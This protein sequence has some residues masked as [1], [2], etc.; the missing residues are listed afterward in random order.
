VRY[1]LDTNALSGILGQRPIAQQLL[2]VRSRDIGISSIVAFEAYFGAFNGGR[3]RE[4]LARLERLEFEV[5]EFDTQD[6]MVAGRVRWELKSR[7]TPIGAYDILIAGQALARDLV[8]VTHN[9]R[10]FSRVD[11]LKVE[12]WE[13]GR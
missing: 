1:L 2:R 9:V 7:G 8:L 12:D 3:P 6:A 10:E 13:G 5:L 11:G 4:N